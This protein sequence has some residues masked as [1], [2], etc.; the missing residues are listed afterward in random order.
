MA[1]LWDVTA[2][3]L[4]RQ[5]PPAPPVVARNL[6]D[7]S[8]VMWDAWAAYDPNAVGYFFSDKQAADDVTAARNA[9]ISYAAYHL[10]LDRYFQGQGDPDNPLAAVM[11]QLCY[12]FDYS[13][14]D[15]TPAGVGMRIGLAAIRAG[16]DDGSNEAG[17]YVDSSY[18]PVNPPLKVATSGTTMN[19]PNK[20]QPL[21][22]PR[23]QA[24]G[25][26]GRPA[27]DIQT[28]IGAQ[29]G[30]VSPFALPASTD[31]VAIDPGPPPA[32]GKDPNLDEQYKQAAIDL[33]TLSATLDPGDG[34]ACDSSCRRRAEKLAAGD[35]F[36]WSASA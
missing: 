14:T 28:F 34:G 11:R 10:L 32:L 25:Q 5:N 18:K 2:L 20:W 17:G 33:L 23:G 15:A 21:E 8:A 13:R 22:F 36:L 6:F 7:M 12:R 31:G 35:H 29:W 19:D 1:R 24:Q 30:F 16:E 26:G 3:D 27:P 4:I 9:A